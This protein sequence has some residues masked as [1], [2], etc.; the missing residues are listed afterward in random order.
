MSVINVLDFKTANLIAAGE[1]VERPSSVVKEL[2][3]NS[4]DA[5]AKKITVEIKNGGISMI[6]VT[7]DGCG[8]S[9]DDLPRC[10]LRHATSKISTGDD[11]AAISTLGFRG[12]ALAAT[13][14]VSRMKITSKRKK[15]AV[16]HT[17][18]VNYGVCSTVS[19]A[20]APDGTA[21]TVSELFSNVP[22]RRKFLKA[23]KTEAA[24]VSSVCEK[25]ALSA[26]EVSFSLLIDGVRRFATSGDGDLKNA[27]Y[28]VLGRQFAQNLI[29]VEGSNEGVT[30]SGAV[31]SPVTARPNRAMELFF[32]NGRYV[33]SAVMSSAL[34]QALTS[35]I[36]SEKFPA[37]LIFITVHPSVVDVNVHPTKAEV[38]FSSDRPI[39][40]AVY[41]AV[42][43]ATEKGQRPEYELAERRQTVSPFVPVTD[44]YT[45]TTVEQIT[46][47]GTPKQEQVPKFVPQPTET[48][49]ILHAY[50]VRAP[51]FGEEI[52]VKV[53]ESSLYEPRKEPEPEQPAEEEDKYRYGRPNGEWRYIGEAFDTYLFVEDGDEVLVIDK[54][55]AHERLRFEELKAAMRTHTPT[56]QMRMIPITVAVTEEE[57]DAAEN[58]RAEL[59]DTGYGFEYTDGGMDITQTPSNI[60]DG[61][62]KALFIGMLS[63]LCEHGAAPEYQKQA[64]FER[65]LYQVCCKGAIKGG[66]KNDE[67]ALTAL[68]SELYEH[69]EVTYC[70]HGRPV[71][72]KMTK[73]A[74]ERRF[75]RT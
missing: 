62:A 71:A 54:H 15:D 41:Y 7:D 44:E 32:I 26:L 42:K 31:C 49:D 10:I 70:P 6:R 55:A 63:E 67:K 75:G 11:L 53:Y 21:V 17:V 47:F 12:E 22:A 18:T 51:K 48:G 37:A 33:R 24:Y 68:I 38:K 30:V 23:D 45:K 13:A 50:A 61:E 58:Y 56:S 20:G 34:E 16:A 46:A 60:S 25:L 9:E 74:M 5:G 52:P 69:P 43:S 64:M 28:A 59:T 3:E 36:P 1:V 8:M 39:Y 4:I 40:D 72:F 27:V 65:A 19:E 14:A 57:A 35:F 29:P 2:V 66:D 73:A